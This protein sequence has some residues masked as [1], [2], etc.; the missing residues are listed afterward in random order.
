[1][2]TNS[3]QSEHAE[4]AASLTAMGLLKPGENFTATSLSG[5]VSCDVWRVDAASRVPVVVKRAL[6]RLRV[7]AEWLAPV[8]RAASEVAWIKLVAGIDQRWVPKVL[9]EDHDHNLF[10]M[11]YLAPEDHPVWKAELAAGHIDVSFAAQVGDALARIHAATAGK[12]EIAEAFDN[13]ALFHALRLEPY[14]LF[15]AQKHPAL[16]PAIR[17]EAARIA[18]SR[19]AVMQGDISPK[20]ILCGPEGPVFIDAETAATGDPVFDL[21]F[22]LNHL[23][24][25]S[26]WHPEWTED[27]A[28]SFIALKDAYLSG[29]SWERPAAADA[30]TARLLPMLFLARVDGKS[31]AEYL[32]EDRDR[33]FVRAAAIQMLIE[34]PMNLSLLAEAYFGVAAWRA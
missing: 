31:P 12:R 11:E 17:A 22:C 16:A 19:I 1:M 8:E 32:T 29:V 5:G 14:L 30:R 24:L 9:A 25:K 3:S 27:Y 23:L 6:P 13:A 33:A 7:A 28:R 2:T 21:A 18:E 20:N 26:V 15:T 34:P 4:I 10:V